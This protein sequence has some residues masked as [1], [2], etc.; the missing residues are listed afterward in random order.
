MPG[1]RVS[2]LVVEDEGVTRDIVVRYFDQAGYHVLKAETGEEALKILD[3]KGA[4]IDWLLTDIVLPGA[5]D[6]WTVGAEFHERDPR[7]PI[8]YMSAF[9]P[10]RQA[11]PV[12]GVYVPKPFS[13]AMVVDLFTR[14]A[15]QDARLSA[16]IRAYLGARV[17]FNN[18]FST[19]DCMVRDISAGGAKLV[20]SGNDPVPQEFELHIPQKGLCYRARI[21][22]RRGLSCGVQ[23]LEYPSGPVRLAS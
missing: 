13:P 3:R 8:V 22:W 5:I 14:L 21:V 18:R 10:R 19:V 15:A 4:G 2:I 12:G 17:V 20:F 23:F 6:G 9:P 7:R 11:L 16:R 1:Q